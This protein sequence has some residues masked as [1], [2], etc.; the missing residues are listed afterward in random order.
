MGSP[1]PGSPAMGKSLG[2]GTEFWQ[3]ACL[4]IGKAERV[5]FGQ[6]AGFGHL[7][8]GEIEAGQ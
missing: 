6:I 8:V 7:P 4:R 2:T 1:F 5:L 3:G